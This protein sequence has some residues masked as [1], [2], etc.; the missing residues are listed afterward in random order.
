M[1]GLHRDI[2][3]PCNFLSARRL[4]KPRERTGGRAGP[5]EGARPPPL[6]AR[7]GISTNHV[8][9]C[10]LCSTE[11]KDQGEPFNQCW[12][13]PTAHV[14]L[15]GLYKQAPWPLEESNPI[16]HQHIFQKGFRERGP[17]RDPTSQGLASIVRVELVLLSS[18]R[19]REI[20]WRYRSEE[21]WTVGVYS[22]VVPIG[23]SLL[24]RGLLLG[25]FSISTSK[26]Q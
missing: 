13:D 4:Q 14:P 1:S 12:F 11:L 25:F 7:R 18:S 26:F 15:R 10:G 24:T 16:I 19:L 20:E 22:E 5:G 2:N 8:Q 17:S 23:S 6:G 21:A 3:V 9:S